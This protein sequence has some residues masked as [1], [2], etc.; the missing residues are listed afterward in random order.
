MKE[1]YTEKKYIKVSAK[2]RINIIN[3]FYEK[4]KRQVEKEEIQV[5]NEK[6]YAIIIKY[7]LNEVNK[8]PDHPFTKLELT[9]IILDVFS[10]SKYILNRFER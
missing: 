6:R 3:D 7:V 9:N 2:N 4:E 5:N 10:N 1:S 8:R